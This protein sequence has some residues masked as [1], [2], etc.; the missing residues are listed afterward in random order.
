LNEDSILLG[1]FLTEG[2]AFDELEDWL[3]NV[4]SRPGMKPVALVV[5]N[6]SIARDKYVEQL[7]NVKA[8][9]RAEFAGTVFE[10]YQA[11]FPTLKWPF[12]DKFHVTANFKKGIPHLNWPVVY[13]VFC[14]GARE[15]VGGF[16]E[17]VSQR[18]QAMMREG[19]I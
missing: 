15:A 6:W 4:G 5:D 12:L 7:Q 19:T 10:R 18:L 1:A 13:R 11:C 14:V 16:D 2:T 3:G 17:T 9:L 8:G